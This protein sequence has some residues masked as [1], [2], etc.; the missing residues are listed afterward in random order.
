ML[1]GQQ[2]IACEARRGSFISED[3]YSCILLSVLHVELDV[4]FSSADG[5]GRHS[6][7]P[8]T[9]LTIT[10]ST[11]AESSLATGVTTSNPVTTKLDYSAAEGGAVRPS[12]QFNNETRQPHGSCRLSI[13]FISDA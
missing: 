12:I 9:I 13:S 10:V 6:T 7:K 11:N 1:L 5:H 8:D 2:E 3:P 4:I